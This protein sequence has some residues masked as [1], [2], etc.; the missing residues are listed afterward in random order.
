VDHVP[1]DGTS[2]QKTP[3]IAVDTDAPSDP[4]VT[5]A[6]TIRELIAVP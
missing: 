3:C 4:H 6:M 1:F 5:D 2:I